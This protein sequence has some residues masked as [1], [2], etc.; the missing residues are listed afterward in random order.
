MTALPPEDL[1]EKLEAVP[2]E[3]EIRDSKEQ[4]SAPSTP[5][6]PALS[7]STSSIADSSASTEIATQNPLAASAPTSLG[8][9]TMEPAQPSLPQP[10]SSQ[11]QQSI[12]PPSSAIQQPIPQQAT[13]VGAA[14]VASAHISVALKI[15]DLL[16]VVLLAGITRIIYYRITE[17]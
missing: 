3:L 17:I 9:N 12:Q 4:T 15:I 7:Q 11:Q 6:K 1:D 16:I 8:G 14:A 5:T 10:Q 13:E 2:Q